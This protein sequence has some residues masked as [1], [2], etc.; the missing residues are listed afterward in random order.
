MMYGI[1]N[2]AIDRRMEQNMSA[3]EIR[4]QR[5]ASVLMKEDKIRN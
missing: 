5:L 4:M 3:L 2:W 1:E